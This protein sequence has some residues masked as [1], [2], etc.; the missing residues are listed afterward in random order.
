MV[1]SKLMINSGRMDDVVAGVQEYMTVETFINGLGDEGLRRKMKKRLAM[2]DDM[3]LEKAIDAAEKLYA[4]ILGQ[5]EM[6]KAA[7]IPM[8][9][10]ANTV[11][12]VFNVN[13]DGETCER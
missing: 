7:A 4:G 10:V 2:E 3:K 1:K 11:S 9:N 6:E 5:K 12:P 8:S 13:I